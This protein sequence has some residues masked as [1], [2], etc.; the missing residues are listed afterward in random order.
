[1]ITA[2]CGTDDGQIKRGAGDIPLAALLDPESSLHFGMRENCLRRDRDAIAAAE[3]CEHGR[4][5]VPLLARQRRSGLEW[6][7]NRTCHQQS[8]T[9]IEPELQFRV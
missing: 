2:G 4:Q 7:L 6:A 3:I 9:L 8:E 1:M 5:S